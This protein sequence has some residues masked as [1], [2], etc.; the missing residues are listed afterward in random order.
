VW[1]EE[2]KKI[3]QFFLR[4]WTTSNR[5]EKSLKFFPF[6]VIPP[7]AFFSSLRI[8]FP[9]PLPTRLAM[10][11]SSPQSML[12]AHCKESVCAFLDLAELGRML[13]V[14]RSWGTAVRSM[15]SI[16]A[17]V[18]SINRPSVPHNLWT[19]GLAHHIARLDL[20]DMGAPNGSQLDS[21]ARYLP[22]LDDFVCKIRAPCLAPAFHPKLSRLLVLCT[23]TW[24]DHDPRGTTINA[25]ILAA[26][27]LDRLR[28]F[29]MRLPSWDRRTSFFPLQNAPVLDTLELWVEDDQPLTDLECVH[30]ILRCP[31]LTSLAVS[32][33]Q[34]ASQLVLKDTQ[35]KRRFTHLSSVEVNSVVD[36]QLQS[37]SQLVA[38]AT[39]DVRSVNFLTHLDALTD[40]SISLQ[41]IDSVP[42]DTFVAA[43]S[44]CTRLEKLD[45]CLVPLQSAH[46]ATLLNPL[47]HLRELTLRKMHQLESFQF[48]AASV[49]LHSTLEYLT[50]KRCQ[51]EHLHASEFKHVLFLS[52]LIN[53]VI[54]EAGVDELD[55]FGRA[56]FTP[57]CS[58]KR[59]NF[60]HYRHT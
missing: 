10:S 5:L 32:L 4:E 37:M 22:N 55:L 50:V 39:Y 16:H 17:D 53:L 33:S 6:F 52:A 9:P 42:T 58:L 28:C 59:L 18:W 1:C 41:L 30:V 44:C 36:R 3:L 35:S 31:H 14:N 12:Y 2:K 26:S 15:R 19:G 40:L 45:M 48:L 47:R 60:F 29:G 38:L 54:V 13:C 56:V 34:E 43:A 20:R 8:P 51:G 7:F 27:R 57:P 25:I 49:H 21:I 23:E 24:P 46:L 11:A